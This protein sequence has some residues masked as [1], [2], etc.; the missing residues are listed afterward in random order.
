MSESFRFRTKIFVFVASTFVPFVQMGKT[1][2]QLELRK[3]LFKG[4][5]GPVTCKMDEFGLKSLGCCPESSINALRRQFRRVMKAWA[6]EPGCRGSNPS[7]A[8]EQLCDLGQ[9]VNLSSALLSLKSS[10]IVSSS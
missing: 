2:I 4:K 8:S 3:V 7:S 1:S 9:L 10:I 5:I 6:L